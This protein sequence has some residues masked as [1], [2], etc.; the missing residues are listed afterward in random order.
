MIYKMKLKTK[1]YELKK[2]RVTSGASE[3]FLA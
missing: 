1:Q 2:Y 3:G